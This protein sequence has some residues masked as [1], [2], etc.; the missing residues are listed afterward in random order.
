MCFIC[1][2]FICIQ[3]IKILWFSSYGSCKFQYCKILRQTTETIKGNWRNSWAAGNWDSMGCIVSLFVFRELR[4][5]P[6][7]LELLEMC[8][9]QKRIYD[10]C[11]R[12]AVYQ[13]KHF[14]SGNLT[15]YLYLQFFSNDESLHLH[16]AA[17]L[18]TLK[19]DKF[20]SLHSIFTLI[21]SL[22]EFCWR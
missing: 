17:F 22:W 14:W 5:F 16:N 13:G 2:V 6:D 18:H 9:N 20:L 15:Q 12:P 4:I 1:W 10:V 7:S 8:I 3:N 11:T 19:R 21:L